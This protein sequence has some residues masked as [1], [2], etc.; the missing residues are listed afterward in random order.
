MSSTNS[1]AAVTS[2]STGFVNSRSRRCL[3]SEPELTPMRI[4]VPSS[5]ARAATSATLS[6]PPMFDPPRPPVVGQAQQVLGGVDDVVGD[7]EHAAVDV[8]GSAGEAGERGTR[9]GQAVRGLVDG[10]VAA[11]R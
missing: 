1:T 4:G 8:G 7:P 3:G 6:G 11:E 2:A 9:A 10:A 5:L